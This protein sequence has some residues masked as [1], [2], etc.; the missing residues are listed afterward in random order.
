MHTESIRQIDDRANRLQCIP[1][2]K[3]E[4][5]AMIKA[6]IYGRVGK[7]G[8]W[9]ITQPGIEMACTILAVNDGTNTEGEVAWFSL[10]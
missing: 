10:D 6:A 1:D 5:Y 8:D 9:I 4:G 2:C 3:I 7:D